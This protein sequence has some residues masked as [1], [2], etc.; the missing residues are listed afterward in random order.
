MGKLKGR[1]VEGDSIWHAECVFMLPSNETA[2]LVSFE[3][4][5]TDEFGIARS[6][7]QWK[8]SIAFRESK[9]ITNEAKLMRILT[10]FSV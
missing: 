2:R 10:L 4:D 7:S 6:I 9:Q 5:S 8:M 3:C 1:W